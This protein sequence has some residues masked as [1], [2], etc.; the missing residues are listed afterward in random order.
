MEPGNWQDDA[1]CVGSD[2][3]LWFAGRPPEQLA[4]K[5]ICAGCGVRAECLA[6][7]LRLEDGLPSSLRFGIRAGLLPAE[8]VAAA[9]RRRT[10][11]RLYGKRPP[12]RVM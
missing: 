11:W 5:A 6:D 9:S 1:S 12:Q 4:A 7:A 10:S 8:R 2:L 3:D